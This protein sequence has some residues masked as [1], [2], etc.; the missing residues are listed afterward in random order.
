MKTLKRL[1]AVVVILMAAAFIVAMAQT[2]GR[3]PFGQRGTPLSIALLQ[4][5]H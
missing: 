1:I 5:N 2:I 3:Q 4:I